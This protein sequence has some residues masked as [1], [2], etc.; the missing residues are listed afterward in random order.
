MIPLYYRC[1]I[2]SGGKGNGKR[3]VPT[4]CRVLQAVTPTNV[5]LHA[6][7]RVIARPYIIVEL[8]L[9]VRIPS[10]YVRTVVRYAPRPFTPK[11]V[12]GR[13]KSEQ[14]RVSFKVYIAGKHTNL[15]VL[16]YFTCKM[17]RHLIFSLYTVSLRVSLC[18]YHI[19]CV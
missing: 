5:R 3:K 19:K 10:R 15:N 8:S 6:L 11:A 17:W 18:I 1:T 16:Y 7:A 4:V 13:A 14:W 12:P 9:R 2:V